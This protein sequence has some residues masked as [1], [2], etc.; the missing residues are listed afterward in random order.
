MINL[1]PNFSRL[2]VGSHARGIRMSLGLTEHELARITGVP[3]QDIYL[4]ERDL[5]VEMEFKI[6]TLKYLWQQARIQLAPASKK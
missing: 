2:S 3:K 6:K 5:P 1:L 4:L